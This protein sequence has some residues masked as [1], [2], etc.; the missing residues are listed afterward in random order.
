MRADEGSER[1]AGHREGNGQRPLRLLLGNWA[2]WEEEHPDRVSLD[3]ESL[4]F[5]GHV[6]R[7]SERKCGVRAHGAW[8]VI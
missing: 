2:K 7:P 5:L 1:F 3:E 4:R 6:K 8:D